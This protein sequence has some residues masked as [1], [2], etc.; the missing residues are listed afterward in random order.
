VATTES[1]II[2]RVSV[3]DVPISV[4]TLDDIDNVLASLL[5]GNEARQVVFVSLWDLLRARR[6]KRYGR[7]LREAALV[8]PTSGSIR[9]AARFL[10]KPEP[11]VCRPFEFVIRLLGALERRSGSLYILGLNRKS[12]QVADANLRLT[13][14]GLRLVGRHPGYFGKDREKDI[15]VAIRKAAPD[16][17]L[18]GSGVPSGDR[19]LFEHRQNLGAG[20]RLW[21]PDVLDIVVGRRRRPAEGFSGLLGRM[22]RAILGK[23]WTIFRLFLVPWF[24]LLLLAHRMLHR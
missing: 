13:Y 11:S 22:T 3:L 15:E 20:A 8:V 7:M 21:A 23:P 9:R 1:H 18:A 19:W 12:V 10:K 24:L 5:S 6:N 2:R 4:F 16:V 14:P 17:L